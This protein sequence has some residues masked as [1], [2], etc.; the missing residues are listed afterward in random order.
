MAGDV[1]GPASTGGLDDDGGAGGPGRL[2]DVLGAVRIVPLRRRHLRQ[3][4]R[5]EEDAY[6]QPWSATLFL[7]EIAQ[8]S[9]RRYTVALIG[10][11]VVGYCGLMLV[12]DEG[13]VT[14]L[15]VD[16]RW[17]RRGIGTLMLL[18]L[19]RAA[20]GVGARHLTLEVRVGNTAA[21]VIYRRFGF[22]P[23][24]VRKNYYPE[25]GEDAIVMWARDID[26]PVYA[27][28]LS[29]IESRLKAP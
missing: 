2:Q 6:P 29:G 13:H 16:P 17:Q 3:V 18:D 25:T 19:A 9:S 11:M 22:A 10:P 15:T 28:R 27:D 1:L 12:G 21:H 7:S 23:A 5:I 4:V 8:R 26:S 14:T 20:P 24:G